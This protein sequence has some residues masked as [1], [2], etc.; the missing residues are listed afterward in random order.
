MLIL[1]QRSWI[2]CCLFLMCSN[3]HALTKILKIEYIIFK[4][5][6]MIE[7]VQ[8]QTR[9]WKHLTSVLKLCSALVY[10]YS[11]LG[12]QMEATCK[13]SHQNPWF[14]SSSFTMERHLQLT[15]DRVSEKKHYL[16][17]KDRRDSPVFWCPPMNNVNQDKFGNWINCGLIK[18]AWDHNWYHKETPEL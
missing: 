16:L 8:L 12:F 1:K 14:Y 15:Y 6:Q 17:L 7:V 4:W 13:S 18:K 5:I 9:F 3:K 11:W 10:K 2:K